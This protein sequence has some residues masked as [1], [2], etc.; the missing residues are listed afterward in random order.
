M[1]RPHL[2]H[3]QEVHDREALQ[4]EAAKLNPLSHPNIVRVLAIVQDK[5]L[6]A[7]MLLEVLGDSLQARRKNGDCAEIHLAF[8]DAVHGLP[9]MHA[10]LLAHHDVNSRNSVSCSLKGR[11]ASSSLTWMRPCR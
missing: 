2:L 6:V 1:K 5:G 9:Y 8:S 4:A 7:G 10:R 11:L 3:D